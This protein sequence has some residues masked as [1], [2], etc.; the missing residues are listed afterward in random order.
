M[1][2][3]TNDKQTKDIEGTSPQQLTAYVASYKHIVAGTLRSSQVVIHAES[4]KAA[5][6]AARV[7]LHE[8]YGDEFRL[9]KVKPW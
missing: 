1:A 2:R 5:E 6:I 9:N 4:P 8:M 7:K 3:D